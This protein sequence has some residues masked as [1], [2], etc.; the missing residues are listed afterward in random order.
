MMPICMAFDPTI[1]FSCLVDA[2]KP[3]TSK[4]GQARCA[5]SSDSSSGKPSPS[6]AELM[7]HF[8]VEE[9]LGLFRP[10]LGMMTH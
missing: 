9:W 1:G 3:G 8:Q 4:W 7:A 5:D 2:D 10:G 6:S